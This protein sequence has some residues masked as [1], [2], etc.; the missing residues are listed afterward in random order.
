MSTPSSGKP[1]V[2]LVV[3]GKEGETKT[4]ATEVKDLVG[5]KKYLV[6]PA[7]FQSLATDP[8]QRETVLLVL[9]QKLPKHLASTVEDW[10]QNG[11]KLLDFDGD[12][13]EPGDLSAIGIELAQE[14]ASYPM[15][16]A[17]D[18]LVSSIKNLVV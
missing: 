11:G 15:P 1:P 6:Y 12:N 3:P 10:V 7:T 13:L 2:I 18:T 4:L 14:T 17:M 8:W 9:G 16:W 5:T